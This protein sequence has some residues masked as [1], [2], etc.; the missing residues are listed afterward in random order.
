MPRSPSG[1]DLP[2]VYQATPGT[3][4]RSEQHNVP[5]EDLAQAMSGTLPRDGSAPMLAN[6]PMN[7]RK[8]TGMGAPTAATDAA[9]K[10]YVDASGNITGPGVVG[11][12][13]TTAGATSVLG[14]GD[15]ITSLS[16]KLTARLGAGLSFVNGA[17]TAAA[18]KI[19]SA[20]DAK[21]GTNNTDT[22]TAL[23]LRD[24][25]NATGPAPV[26]AVRAWGDFTEA[27]TGGAITVNG[28]G[29]VASVTR[30]SVGVFRI[31]FATAMSNANYAVSTTGRRTDNTFSMVSFM[32]GSAKTAAE[33][34]LTLRTSGN[35]PTPGTITFQVVA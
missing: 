1:Y 8:V 27:P 5:L 28:S 14:F 15:G 4:I 13:A 16:G 33:F 34:T 21:A 19:V 10:A 32:D 12:E 31:T 26:F 22:M 11:R 7:G 17:I 35:D 2:A 9:T 29:N 18:M 20:A 24:A 3:T 6:L 23:R 25:L 30:V